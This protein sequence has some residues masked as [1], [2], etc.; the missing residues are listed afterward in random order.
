MAR[1]NLKKKTQAGTTKFII[2]FGDYDTVSAIVVPD[3]E[4]E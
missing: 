1:I 3:M 4:M 2:S